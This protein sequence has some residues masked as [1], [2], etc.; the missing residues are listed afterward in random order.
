MVDEADDAR[1][2]TRMDEN[3]GGLE[4]LRVK[5]STPVTTVGQSCWVTV[6]TGHGVVG[7]PGN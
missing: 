7:D 4:E 2:S 5:W 1:L 3:G 6:R